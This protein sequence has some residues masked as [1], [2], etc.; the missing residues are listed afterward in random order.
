MH[1]NYINYM[2]NYINYLFKYIN[3]GILSTCNIYSVILSIRDIYFID[4]K[5]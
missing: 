3:L 4:Q 5:V 1:I 2:L